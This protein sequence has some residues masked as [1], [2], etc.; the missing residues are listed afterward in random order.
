MASVSEEDSRK[1][2][3]MRIY[4]KDCRYWDPKGKAGE[5]RR[6]CPVIIWG[7][8][9]HEDDIQTVFPETYGSEWCGEA[10]QKTVSLKIPENHVMCVRCGLLFPIPDGFN[11]SDP[12]AMF[13]L[14]CP[15]C[16]ARKGA[17]S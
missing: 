11:M 12:L 13:V 7:R 15:T 5:C 2:I 10:E 16:D 3:S 9:E 1:E 8:G 4:C 14:E 17:G 6:H